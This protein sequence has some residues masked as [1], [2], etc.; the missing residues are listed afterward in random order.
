MEKS[1][2]FVFFFASS[3][4]NKLKKAVLVINIIAIHETNITDDLPQ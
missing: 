1:F 4:V 3:D 2:L